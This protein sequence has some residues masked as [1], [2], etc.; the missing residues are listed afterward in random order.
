MKV[1]GCA[2]FACWGS[3]V[4]VSARTTRESEC[5]IITQSNTCM[6]LAQNGRVFE[7]WRLGVG[8]RFD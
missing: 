2:G 8:L 7:L 6:G 1:Q 4:G 5:G 3:R